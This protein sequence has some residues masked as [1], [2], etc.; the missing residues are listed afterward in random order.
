M[1]SNYC[2]TD[3]DWALGLHGMCITDASVT[4]LDHR[5][6]TDR[7]ILPCGSGW[8]SVDSWKSA[9]TTSSWSQWIVNS[10]HIFVRQHLLAWSILLACIAYCSSMLYCTVLHCTAL[11]CTALH[12]TT[13]Y[14]TTKICIA[15]SR[16]AKRC[17][18]VAYRL[19]Y[20]KGIGPIVPAFFL[21]FRPIHII[22]CLSNKYL[23]RIVR[24]LLPTYKYSTQFERGSSSIQAIRV[25][26]SG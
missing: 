12:Y 21:T 13:L 19:N 17:G 24:L 16:Q 26:Q 15:P 22:N 7:W 5:P 10:K 6:E 23:Y 14:Y 3:T 20:I 8:K 4:C 1:Y 11:H 25:C 9:T 18:R 2:W